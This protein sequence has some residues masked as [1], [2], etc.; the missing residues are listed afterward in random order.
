MTGS[1]RWKSRPSEVQ[2]DEWCLQIGSL[3]RVWVPRRAAAPQPPNHSMSPHYHSTPP[4]ASLA[5]S[6]FVPK[7]VTRAC[8]HPSSP[9]VLVPLLS[10]CHRKGE[11]T[12]MAVGSEVEIFD[13]FLVSKKTFQTCFAPALYHF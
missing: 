12:T 3:C 13:L 6:P 11:G 2:Q 8:S 1:R 10:P 4:S 5:Q 7:S 9:S